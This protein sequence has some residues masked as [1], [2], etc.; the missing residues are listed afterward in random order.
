VPAEDPR[1]GDD[2]D[3]DCDRLL[4]DDEWSLRPPARYALHYAA[5]DLP[6]DAVEEAL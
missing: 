2:R 4:V 3:G 6:V 5:I 1:D